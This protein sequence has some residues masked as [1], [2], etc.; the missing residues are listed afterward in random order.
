MS[1]DEA[2]PVHG[3]AGRAAGSRLPDLSS[4]PPEAFELVSPLVNW[5]SRSC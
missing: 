5:S 2:R 4:V 3:E 1:P